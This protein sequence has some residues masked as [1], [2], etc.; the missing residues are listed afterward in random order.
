MNKCQSH[1]SLRREEQEEEKKLGE[2]SIFS[3]ILSTCALTEKQ[4]IPIRSNHVV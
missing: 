2:I 1:T 3:Q 4:I